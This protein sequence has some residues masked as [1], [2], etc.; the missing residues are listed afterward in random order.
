MLLV[1]AGLM[2]AYDVS[3]GNQVDLIPDRLTWEGYEFLEAAKNKSAWE[4]TKRLMAESGG[5]VFQIG[6]PILYDL[7]K[8]QLT[9]KYTNCK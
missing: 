6:I 5:F 2:K 1:E 4:K 7:I 9:G 8:Q 3:A